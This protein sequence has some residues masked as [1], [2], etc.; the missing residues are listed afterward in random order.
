[1]KKRFV[2]SNMQIVGGRNEIWGEYIIISAFYDFWICF[3]IFC[4]L[5]RIN[6]CCITDNVHLRS[7]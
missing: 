3:R 1:M 4:E 2:Q 6:I 7:R 5:Q